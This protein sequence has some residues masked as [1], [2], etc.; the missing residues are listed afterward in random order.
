MRILI[1]S[2]TNASA[3]VLREHVASVRALELPPRV[4]TSLAYI[5]DGLSD[6]ALAVLEDAG[7]DVAD[8]L[9]KPEDA[10]HA[11][12][13]VTHEW[14]LPTFGWLAREKQRLLDLAVERRYDGIFFVDSDLVLGPETLASLIYADKDVTSAVFWTR[15]QPDAPALPQVWL[16]HPY[17]LEGR[18]LTQPEFLRKLH[19]R[20]LVRVAGLGACTLIRARVFDRVRWFPLVDGLPTWGMWQGEDRHF[21]VNAERAHVELWADAWPDIFHIYRP[22]DLAKLDA[23]RGSV[24][25]R[26]SSADIGDYV[27][28]TL[29]PVEERGLLGHREHVRGRLGTLAL[30]PEVEE[31]IRETPVGSTRIVKL[32]F[33][34][35]Y[36]IPDYA[37]TSKHVLLRMLDVKTSDA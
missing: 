2:V 16:Q 17:G 21:C 25:A 4:T 18:G 28:F 14:A 31:A 33:P 9:P 19:G 22:S 20:E 32:D 36:E 30:L 23:W 13:E 15:W 29:E 5:S 27:S 7:A 8:A 35:W 11:V 24:R 3:E 1:A 10:T 6:E 12:T 37:G 34:P 26:A